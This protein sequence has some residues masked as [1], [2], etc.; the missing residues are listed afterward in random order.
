MYWKYK[1]NL[2]LWPP[3]RFP[4]VELVCTSPVDPYQIYIPTMRNISIQHAW[5]TESFERD[6][7][8]AKRTQL[9][10]FRTSQIGDWG[11]GKRI[12]GQIGP[13]ISY[14]RI[15]VGKCMHLLPEALLLDFFGIPCKNKCLH[16]PRI[17]SHSFFTMGLMNQSNLVHS[18]YFE[19]PYAL[20]MNSR[21]LHVLLDRHLGLRP[22][23]NSP[24]RNSAK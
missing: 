8:I 11:G 21:F 24:R 2:I 1:T 5:C 14:E 17:D 3:R 4:Y 6:R 16:I 9:S 10:Y 23:P 18:W 12:G 20:P 15:L 7:I 13:F 22:S 19:Q